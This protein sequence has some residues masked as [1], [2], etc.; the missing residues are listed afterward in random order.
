MKGGSLPRWLGSGRAR[1]I[2]ASRNEVAVVAARSQRHR[3]RRRR[4]R[5]RGVPRRSLR[6]TMHLSARSERPRR[7]SRRCH[8]GARMPAPEPPPPESPPSD[9]LRPSRRHLAARTIRTK[10]CRPSHRSPEPPEPL[11]YEPPSAPAVLSPV[12]SSC[13]LFPPSLFTPPPPVASSRRLP[14]PSPSAA[15]SPP[16]LPEPPPSELAAATRATPTPSRHHPNCRRPSRPTHPGG[17]AA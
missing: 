16:E 5:R 17:A 4:R 11:P 2:R 15:S 8:A 14:A 1:P 3:G 12:V 9:H 10:C 13:R 7:P 6:P